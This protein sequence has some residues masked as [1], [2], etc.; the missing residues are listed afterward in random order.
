VRRLPLSAFIPPRQSCATAGRLRR[1]VRRCVLCLTALAGSAASIVLIV[2]LVFPF[3]V[4]TLERWPA[5][6]RVEDRTGRP[7]LQ[8]V[9]KDEQWRFP[10]PL[11]E[12][13]PWI[14]QA[15]IAA[16]DERFYEHSGVD[17]TALLRAVLQNLQ[18]ADV[19]SGASTIT[20]QLCR[21]VDDRPRTLTAKLI[22]TSRALNIERRFSKLEIL[23]HYL[24]LAPYGG[25]I[26]GVEAASQ[27]YFRKNACDLSLAEAALLAGLPK[28]PTQFRPDRYPDRA[29]TRQT[30]V[31][32]R[33]REVGMIS[34]EQEQLAT[35]WQADCRSEVAQQ[36]NMLRTAG[37][38]TTRSTL[39]SAS[40]YQ[41]ETQASESIARNPDPLAC[42]SFLY[43]ETVSA[44]D[45]SKSGAHA[46]WLALRRRPE[47]GRTTIDP[48]CQS[49]TEQLVNHHRADLPAGS[50]IAVVVIDISS[51]EIVALVG[52]ADFSD[53]VDGQVNGVLA[54]RSPGSAL[55]PF[56][57]ATAFDAKRLNAESV[58]DDS[59]IE[60]GGWRPDN[61]DS[62]FRGQMTVAD[63]LRE[64]RNVPAILLLEA[65]G[66]SRCVGV[67]N[68]VGV[69][70]PK[71]VERLGGL[72]IAVGAVETTLLD[73]TNAY[74][75]LG[76]DGRFT[77]PRLF[78]DE[79]LDER[80][81]L[82]KPA[83]RTVNAILASTERTP[84]GCEHVPA[85]QLPWFMWKTGTSSGRRDAWAVGHNGR[86]AIG[87]WVG[88]FSGAGHEAFVGREAAEPLLARLFTS[89]LIRA[90]KV[91]ESPDELLVTLPLNLIPDAGRNLPMIVS[92]A[93]NSEWLCAD[94]R[95]ALI[96]VTVRNAEEAAWFLN[97]R[98]ATEVRDS[99]NLAP[100]SYELRCIA[101]NG[102]ATAV[103]FSVASK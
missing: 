24:N 6:P 32:R 46:A 26:R 69:R 84:H 77:K 33:M 86:F 28:S 7:L 91:P 61:F 30:Y 3:P 66:S 2:Q 39:T 16:E 67:L 55:K 80:V 60:R 10:I 103:R 94:G 25:N 43:Q 21:M 56:F 11:D 14:V 49:T 97:G 59:S 63:A 31:L 89:R 64:S 98:P 57:Y 92:P 54:R 102:Q 4:Q 74:A 8:L 50:D 81:V 45:R 72:A 48:S 95:S 41:H 99:L 88:R 75:T 87:V 100:G 65:L 40:T 1:T 17:T 83:C 12:M 42:D 23:E 76:R 18:A 82:G 34:V 22:E 38:V 73:L 71:N 78:A 85:G 44:R 62:T 9:G 15:T 35:S 27:R 96:P 53:P 51:S 101:S 29:T 47:G 79:P 13:S 5:S 37:T 68:S 90:T 58:V 20:M 70:L 52:S 19:V 36:D 93:S